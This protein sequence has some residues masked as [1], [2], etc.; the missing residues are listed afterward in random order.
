MNV[1]VLYDTSDFGILPETRLTIGFSEPVLKN[2]SFVTLPVQKIPPRNRDQV[3]R[4]YIDKTDFISV[5]VGTYTFMRPWMHFT[6]VYGF[7]KNRPMMAG[8]NAFVPD[9]W[10]H[11]IV[12]GP[13]PFSRVK[14]Q[15]QGQNIRLY[16]LDNVLDV[17]WQPRAVIPRKSV[18]YRFEGDTGLL[19]EI[20]PMYDWVPGNVQDNLFNWVNT[21]IWLAG[22]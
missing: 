3:I 7:T 1:L 4:E 21:S 18:R 14:W 20:A 8:N 2:F 9:G 10:S 22:L 17:I 16:V 11:E 19:S 13:N 5:G 15:I 6:A 12:N